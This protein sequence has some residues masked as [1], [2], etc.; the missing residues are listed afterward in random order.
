MSTKVKSSHFCSTSEPFPRRPRCTPPPH[1]RTLLVFP[2]GNNCE[3][4]SVYVEAAGESPPAGW[5]R[6]AE[7]CITLSSRTDKKHSV[8]KSSDHTFDA[9]ESDWGFTQFMKIADLTDSNKGYIVDDIV[10]ITCDIAV[11]TSNVAVFVAAA[12]AAAAQRPKRAQP[13]KRLL[14]TCIVDPAAAA[15]AAAAAAR[16]TH[17]AAAAPTATTATA[18]ATTAAT[19]A[20]AAAAAGQPPGAAPRVAIPAGLYPAGTGGL[21]YIP[22]GMGF[23]SSTYQLNLRRFS[24]WCG[25]TTLHISQNVLTL[26]RK[27]GACM[28][29]PAGA[30][31][32]YHEPVNAAMVGWCRLTLSN[33]C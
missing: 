8:K 33:P 11:A 16:P 24:H 13:P 29:L 10:I 30:L 26:S 27:A 12:L 25:E 7:F 4:V 5:G 19:A 18:T 23:H 28:P 3:F 31:A 21:L 6:C 14:S 17:T 22:A 20:A 32:N 9:T 1:R 15:L 2:K